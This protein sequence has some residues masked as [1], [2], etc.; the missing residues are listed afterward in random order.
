MSLRRG[1]KE[2]S[3]RKKLDINM[4]DV[5]H[6]VKYITICSGALLIFSLLAFLLTG[7]NPN[8]NVIYAMVIGINAF[9]VFTGILFLRRAYKKE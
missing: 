6:F 7:S 5:A 8:T 4:E 1:N 2:E 9:V 3:R